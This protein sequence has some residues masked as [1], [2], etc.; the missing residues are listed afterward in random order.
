MTLKEHKQNCLK[1]FSCNSQSDPWSLHFS[2]LLFTSN[3]TCN[4]FFQDFSQ[5][6]PPSFALWLNITQWDLP[7]DK[8]LSE[9]KIHHNPIKFSFHPKLVK[10]KRDVKNYFL[11]LSDAFKMFPKGSASFSSPVWR[12]IVHM[13]RGFWWNKWQCSVFSLCQN[14]SYGLFSATLFTPALDPIRKILKP[15]LLLICLYTVTFETRGKH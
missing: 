14:P 12:G 10:V 8:R 9:W 13:G 2:L 11:N 1:L 4:V 5:L 3:I 7:T 6:W 15:P